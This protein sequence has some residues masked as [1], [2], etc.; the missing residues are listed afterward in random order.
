[1]LFGLLTT[2]PRQG[3]L[4]LIFIQKNELKDFLVIAKTMHLRPL[5]AAKAQP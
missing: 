5:S 3:A 1:M 4:C 2:G